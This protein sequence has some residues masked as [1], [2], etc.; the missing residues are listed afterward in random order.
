[1]RV[2][3]DVVG[4]EW[5]GKSSAAPPPPPPPPPAVSK[6]LPVVTG[7]GCCRSVGLFPPLHLQLGL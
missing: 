6:L 1:M 2:L 3:C 7:G 4:S 5:R